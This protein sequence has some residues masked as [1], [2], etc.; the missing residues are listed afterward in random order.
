MRK[1]KLSVWERDA[2]LAPA[3]LAWEV[4]AAGNT[5]VMD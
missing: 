1:P 5:H 4:M 2:C 3:S